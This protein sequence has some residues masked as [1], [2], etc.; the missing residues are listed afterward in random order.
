VSRLL[1]P[2]L[3]ERARARAGLTF[4]LLFCIALAALLAGCGSSDN[5]VASKSGKEILAASKAAAESAHSVHVVGRSSQGRASLAIDLRLA[6]DGGR[7]HIS[8]LGLDFEVIRIGD[9]VYV[10]GSPAFYKRL[11]A[12]QGITLHVPA[13]TWLKA[14]VN[15]GP[16]AQLAALAE[17]RGELERLL[18][19]PGPV[20]RG[21]S[22]TIKGQKAIELKEKTKVY[23]GSLFVA[24]TGKPYPLLLVKSGGR[25]RGRLTFSGWGE[26]VSLGAPSP[27][28]EVGGLKG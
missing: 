12:T 17:L 24:T 20:I 19:T 18:S 7:G 9:T 5:G 2:A 6:G 13:G 3:P 28:V 4:A 21:A 27:A 22:T 26:G 25:E 1:K 14:P 15:G 11:G 16:L 23:E 8:F 10:K